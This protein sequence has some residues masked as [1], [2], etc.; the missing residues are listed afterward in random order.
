MLTNSILWKRICTNRLNLP[1]PHPLP[2]LNV[3]VPYIFMADVPFA[4][5]EHIMKPFPGNHNVGTKEHIFTQKLS[6]ARVVVE[7]TFGGMV[8]KFRISKN[9]FNYSQRRLVS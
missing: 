2:D 5:S 9:L 3:D 1:I 4:L 6:R 8:K 7:N